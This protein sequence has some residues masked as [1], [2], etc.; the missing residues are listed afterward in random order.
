MKPF[1]R[2]YGAGPAHLLV[3][4]ACLALAAYAASFLLGDPA[5]FTILVWF[6][7]AAV[8]HD[9]VLFPLAALA[10]RLLCRAPM[11]VVNHLRLPLLGAGL[12]FVLFLPGIVRQGGDTHLAATGLTQQPYLGRWLW[13]V[14]AMF[15]L[16]GLV[17]AVRALRAR[18][19]E[20]DS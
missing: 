7:G 8:A 15:V 6:A 16:S 12:T 18:W 1:T 14:L 3:L 9:F 10:D 20:E 4:L 2:L 13:L 19:V 11:R 17:Y 5:L